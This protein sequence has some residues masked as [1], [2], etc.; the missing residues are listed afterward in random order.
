MI[1]PKASLIVTWLTVSMCMLI[2]CFASS[3]LPGI[4]AE[5]NNHTDKTIHDV[6]LVYTGG[7]QVIAELPPN[8]AKQVSIDV[9]GDSGLDLEYADG[10]QTHQHKLPIYVDRANVGSIWLTIEKGDKIK[11]RYNFPP[12]PPSSSDEPEKKRSGP[13]R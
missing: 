11:W 8:V 2:G 7:T 9:T 10:A 4:V 3:A 1:T 5:V 13:H 6:K 12:F